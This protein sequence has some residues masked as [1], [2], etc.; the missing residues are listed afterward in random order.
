MQIRGDFDDKGRVAINL[1]D[2]HL[3]L[4]KD[5]GEGWISRAVY[6]PHEDTGW[7]ELTTGNVWY[8]RRDGVVYVRV[9]VTPTFT[10]IPGATVHVFATLPEGCRPPMRM[11]SVISVEHPDMPARC[12][13]FFVEPDGGIKMWSY[14]A[15]PA[16]TNVIGAISFP[17]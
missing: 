3:E 4:F 15:I 10:V 9:F 13:Q 2:T 8:R 1:F 14:T 6:I 16:G 17:V 11:E 12:A 5:E 7:V